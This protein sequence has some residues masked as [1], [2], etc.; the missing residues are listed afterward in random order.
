MKQET[1]TCVTGRR[2]WSDS[3]NTLTVPLEDL[4]DFHWR[5]VSGGVQTRSPR[6][7]LHARMLCSS[8][9]NGSTFPHSCGHG[10]PPHDILVCVVKKDND[11]AVYEHCAG[12]AR[13]GRWS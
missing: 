11:K 4:W 3:A 8:I 10:P 12:H 13:T 7:F 5:S 1:V 2:Q 9:P 6:P